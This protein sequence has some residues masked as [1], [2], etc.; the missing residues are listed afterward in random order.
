LAAELQREVGVAAILHQSSGGVFE[1][2]VDGDLLFSKTKL[3]RFPEPGEVHGII[4]SRG[5]GSSKEEDQHF[6]ANL[7]KFIDGQQQQQ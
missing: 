5:Q 7:Q 6:Q 3:G 1:V 2:E 4:Q